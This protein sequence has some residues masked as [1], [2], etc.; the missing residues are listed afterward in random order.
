MFFFLCYLLFNQ[1]INT[2]TYVFFPLDASR[3]MLCDYLFLIT[4]KP[5]KC[6]YK[7]GSKE[8]TENFY[9]ITSNACDVTN[10]G[11]NEQKSRANGR[12]W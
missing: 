2:G 7:K 10:T 4:N 1:H 12:G 11:N 5:A 9:L 3:L 8:K 6:E